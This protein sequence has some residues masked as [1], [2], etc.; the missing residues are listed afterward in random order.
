MKIKKEIKKDDRSDTAQT[1]FMQNAGTHRKVP[2][3]FV[4][5]NLHSKSKSRGMGT[6][7]LLFVSRRNNGT[8]LISRKQKRNQNA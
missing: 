7:R 1:V 6:L 5:K 8:V 2:M 4:K 3:N